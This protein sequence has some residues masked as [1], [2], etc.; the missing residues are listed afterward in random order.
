[1]NR[2][3]LARLSQNNVPSFHIFRQVPQE[4]VDQH[5]RDLFAVRIDPPDVDNGFLDSF[6]SEDA[7]RPNSDLGFTPVREELS[8]FELSW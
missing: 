1:M 3:N 6:H 4:E 7:R 8:G 2:W 5:G